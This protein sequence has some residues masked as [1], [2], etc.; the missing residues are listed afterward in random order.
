MDTPREHSSMQVAVSSALHL[1][2]P[3]PC[4]DS[5]GR[6][7]R[8][9]RRALLVWASRCCTPPWAVRPDD[10]CRDARLPAKINSLR[11]LAFASA[12]A[13]EGGISAS[14]CAHWK[15]T[16]AAAS[17]RRLKFDINSMNS[18]LLHSE[19]GT[20]NPENRIYSIIAFLP[21]PYRWADQF[22]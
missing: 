16:L 11:S 8:R 5:L 14:R 13:V 6:F 2:T 17:G 21:W 15:T 7:W 9:Y 20:E 18:E 1:G 22:D 19:P 3:R 12:C 10:C 4:F